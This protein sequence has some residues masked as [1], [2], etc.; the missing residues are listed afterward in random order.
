MKRFSKILLAASLS[1]ASSVTLAKGFGHQQTVNYAGQDVSVFE[2]SARVLGNAQGTAPELV[3]DIYDG[4]G[5]EKV[6]G[7]KIQVMSRNYS[8]AADALPLKE[9]NGWM[10]SRHIHRGIKLLLGIPVKDGKVELDHASVLALGLI[11]DKTDVPEFKKED[12]IRPRGQQIVKK[13]AQLANVTVKVDELQLPD[14]ES[15]ETSGGG[16]KLSASADINGKPLKV[17]I[18]STFR[19]FNTAKPDAKRGFNADAR[20]I[21]K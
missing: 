14:M 11:I 12:K 20:L 21:Q 6:P 19:E 8:L 7:Y 1:L 18:N 15:G 9:G 16:V 5:K 3:N 2:T 4:L 10:D 13:E 17:S